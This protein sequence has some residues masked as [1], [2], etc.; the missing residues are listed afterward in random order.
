M[1]AITKRASATTGS[2]EPRVERCKAHGEYVSKPYFIRRRPPA[3]SNLEGWTGCPICALEAGERASAVEQDRMREERQQAARLRLEQRLAGAMIPERF[4]SKSF[5]NYATENAAQEKAKADLQHYANSFVEVLA[6]GR[7]LIL[8]GGVGTGK[9]HLACAVANVIV[10]KGHSA[11]F[12]TVQQVIRHVRSAWRASDRTEEEAIA[13]LV[14]PDL[15]ILDEVG[16][17][18]GTEGE[19]V[20]LFDVMNARYSAGKPSIVITNLTIAEAEQ[21]LGIRVMDRLRENGGKAVKFDWKS[22]RTKQ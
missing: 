4:V 1:T 16:V 17:Q 11:L 19:Q 2:S 9:T 12:R 6:V 14:A 10:G 8:A 22:A 15:L 18:Y 5:E 21:Y 20:T 7:C 3:P 13:E